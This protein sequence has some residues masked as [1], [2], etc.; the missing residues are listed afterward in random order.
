MKKQLFYIHGGSAFS[1]ED[2][3]MEYLKSVAIEPPLEDEDRPQRWTDTLR[4][5][6]GEDWEVFKPRMPNAKKAKYEEWKLWFERHLEWLRDGVVLLGWSQGGYFLAKY[7]VENEFPV[8]VQALFLLAA[9]FEPAEFGYEDGG[10]FAFDTKKAAVL[11]KRAQQVFIMHSED[12][13]AVPFSHARKYHQAVPGSV[14]LSFKSRNHFVIEAFPELV[15]RI[16][17]VHLG[18]EQN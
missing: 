10:D 5:D 6:V 1:S 3:Y 15:E 16:K 4:E 9:P 18:A 11:Q 7:L 2:K 17:Q 13:P 12:D 8:K 14:L